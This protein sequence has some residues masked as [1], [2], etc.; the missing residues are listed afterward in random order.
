M[1]RGNMNLHETARR[2]AGLNEGTSEVHLL[3]QL[4]GEAVNEFC[5]PCLRLDSRERWLRLYVIDMADG[6]SFS[7]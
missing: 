3:H 1:S 2:I 5:L 7:C 6:P 4:A